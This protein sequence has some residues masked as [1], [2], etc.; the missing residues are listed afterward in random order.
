MLDRLCQTG[1]NRPANDKAFDDYVLKNRPADDRVLWMCR[2][3]NDS[4]RKHLFRRWLLRNKG[5][6]G[7]DDIVITLCLPYPLD[8]ERVAASVEPYPGR[9]TTHIVIGDDAAVD[10]ELFSWVQQA[11]HFSAVK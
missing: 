7:D 11:Y 10:D 1:Y 8:S 9:W 3:C 4:Q 6:R 5:D 2:F